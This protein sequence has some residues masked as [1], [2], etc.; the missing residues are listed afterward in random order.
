MRA[1]ASVSISAEA[2]SV[3]SR[4]R[5]LGLRNIGSYVPVE[6]QSYDRRE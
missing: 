1:S 2:S 6:A 4:D 3:Q 5:R